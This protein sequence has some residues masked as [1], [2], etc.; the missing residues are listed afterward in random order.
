MSERPQRPVSKDA[1]QKIA[2]MLDDDAA[3][4]E[5]QGYPETAEN[6]RQ[7]AANYRR[8]NGQ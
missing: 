5:R 8:D 6:I 2:Q 1:Q 3:Q 4:A 7:R